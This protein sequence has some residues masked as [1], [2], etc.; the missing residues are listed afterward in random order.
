VEIDRKHAGT[1]L[2]VV[3]V[4]RLLDCTMKEVEATL[5]NYRINDA[6]VKISGEVTM[7]EIEDAI[8]QTLSTNPP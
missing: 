7:E 4:G 3:L 8:F 1:A 2:R 5:H 6:I